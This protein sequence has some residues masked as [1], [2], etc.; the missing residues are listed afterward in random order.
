MP[1]NTF[2]Q[3]TLGWELKAETLDFFQEFKKRDEAGFFEL[4]DLLNQYCR[5]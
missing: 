3:S 2:I 4:F 1:L 5:E